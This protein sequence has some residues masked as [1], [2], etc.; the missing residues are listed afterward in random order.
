MPLGEGEDCLQFNSSSNHIIRNNFIHQRNSKRENNHVDGILALWSEGFRVYDN[1]IIV[2]SNAQGQAIIIRA[3]ADAANE[4]PVIIYNNFMYQGGIWDS[5]EF[6]WTSVMNL[7]WQAQPPNVK[8]PTFVAH[9]TIVSNGRYVQG[10]VH[11]VPSTFVNNIV[12]QFGDGV[13][14]SSSYWLASMRV[15][16]EI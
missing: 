12:A 15:F 3:W 10:V 11:E 13:T 14:P 16:Q 6:P 7:R 5:N 4:D 9:N 1:V 8:P 2:D